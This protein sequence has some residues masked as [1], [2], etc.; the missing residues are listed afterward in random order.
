VIKLHRL[1]L[2]TTLMMLFWAATVLAQVEKSEQLGQVH[3][4]VEK[5]RTYYGKL[6][7]LSAGSDTDR[8]TL[9]QAKA[10][11]AKE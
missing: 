11:L 3:F 9:Q 2:C 6:V 10:F 5:A 1:W 8:P 7:V 4:E